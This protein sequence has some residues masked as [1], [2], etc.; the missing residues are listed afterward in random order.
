MRMSRHLVL[1]ALGLGLPTA[2]V[3]AP[4]DY[5]LIHGSVADKGTTVVVLKGDGGRSYYVTADASGVSSLKAGKPVTV[6]G[7]EGA[8]PNEASGLLDAKRTKF[9]ASDL[10]AG[11]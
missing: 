7:V 3:A 11:K 2:A 9:T 4:G 5:H 8:Y 6:R 1:L 10:E